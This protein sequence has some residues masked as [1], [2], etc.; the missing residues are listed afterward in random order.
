VWRALLLGPEDLRPR[1]AALAAAVGPAAS[2]HEGVSVAGGGSL[3]GEGLPSVLVEIDPDPL[4]DDAVLARL[5]AGDPPVIAR[6][7]H[8]R[9]VI[10]LRTVPPEQ[11]AAVALALL[12]ALDAP[13]GPQAPPRTPPG[14]GGR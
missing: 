3:P 9:V 8:G 4:G 7:E 13:G 10:D 14:P 11:D 5:R 6:A 12:S 1:A 2:L